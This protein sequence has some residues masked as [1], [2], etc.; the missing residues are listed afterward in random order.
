MDK[1]FLEFWSHLMKAGAL[2]PSELNQMSKWM[3]GGFSGPDTLSPLFKKAYG[4]DQVSESLPDYTRLAQEAVSS[5]QES[6][7]TFVS[8]IGVSSIG[9]VPKETHLALIKKY[10]ALKEKSADQ[11]ETIKHLK[12]MLDDK[13]I[14]ADDSLR[15][16]KHMLHS[17]NEQFQSLMKTIGNFYKND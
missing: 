8:S 5:F 2:N 13:G 16:F 11:E 7:K 9:M 14:P 10:E 6:L 15:Q 12:A 1:S 4:L 17:Q 3:Q